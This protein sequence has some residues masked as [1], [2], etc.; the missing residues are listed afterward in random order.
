MF[1][2]TIMTT[3][4]D[5]CPPTIRVPD[6]L[7]NQEWWLRH[8]RTGDSDAQIRELTEYR[9]A[10]LETEVLQPAGDTAPADLRLRRVI[11]AY[12]KLAI[13]D[14]GVVNL[15]SC[16]Q[17]HQGTTF[18]PMVREGIESFLETLQEDLTSVIK[19]HDRSHVIDPA[20]AVQS[21]LGIIHW[22]VGSY[23][24]EARLSQDEAAAQI[25]F[26]A[27]HGLVAQPLLDT[28]KHTRRGNAA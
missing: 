6:R 11:S 9:M 10:R 8:H 25:T 24:A 2:E 28:D 21:L 14:P 17:D 26:L 13:T 16:G 18:S 4:N 23:R 1:W 15:L 20:V 7:S 5:H 22:G 27:L 12:V 19:R 3:A